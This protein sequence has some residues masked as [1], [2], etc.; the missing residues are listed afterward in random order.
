M[1]EGVPE[2]CYAGPPPRMAEVEAGGMRFFY[3]EWEESGPTVVLWHGITSSSGS[4][5]RVAPA[6]AQ[7]GFHV[8]T[9]DLP[10]HGMSSD[11]LDGYAVTTTAGLLDAFMAAL[12][13]ADPIIVGHSW[14]GMNALVHATV[15]KRQVPGHAYALI[16]PALGIPADPSAML[17]NFLQGIGDPNDD[18]VQARIADANPRWDPCDVWWA[19]WARSLARPAAVRGFFND[20]AGT[21]Y[22]ANLGEVAIPMLMQIADPDQGRGLFTLT[23][24]P[25]IVAQLSSSVELQSVTEAGHNIHRDDFDGS[26]AQ[27]LPFI[28]RVAQV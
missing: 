20:N 8:Y 17:E 13:I 14:G 23:T 18:E 9:P 2:G 1:I 5:W 19:G 11:S 28:Q 7:H 4:W 10:G 25:P 3:R 12:D 6:L 26:M 15:A 27:V 22:T 16:D 24:L 21:N